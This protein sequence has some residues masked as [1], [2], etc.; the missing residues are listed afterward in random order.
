M[1]YA[2][3]AVVGV[4]VGFIAGTLVYRKHSGDIDKIIQ[5]I[6]KLENKNG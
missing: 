1:E 4:F 2:I 3:V 5:Q 6:E